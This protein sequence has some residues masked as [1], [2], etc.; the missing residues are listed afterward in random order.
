MTKKLTDWKRSV[1]I[2]W[3]RLTKLEQ[4]ADFEMKQTL[5]DAQAFLVRLHNSRERFSASNTLSLVREFYDDACIQFEKRQKKTIQDSENFSIL[6]QMSQAEKTRLL[7]DVNR[8]LENER[9]AFYE[10]YTFNL[11][12]FDLMPD[13]NAQATAPARDITEVMA[14]LDKLYLIYPVD[15]IKIINTLRTGIDAEAN[16]YLTGNDAYDIVTNGTFFHWSKVGT[17]VFG[18]LILPEIVIATNNSKV[19]RR[20]GLAILQSGLIAIKLANSN[21]EARIRQ[22]FSEPAKPERLPIPE[23][24]EADPVAEYIGGGALLIQN[25][26][27]TSGSDLFKIQKFDNLDIDSTDGFDAKQMYSTQRV[28]FGIHNERPFLIIPWNKAN[29]QGRNS[30]EIQND[31]AETGFSDVIQFDGGGEFY[32]NS[33][34][35]IITKGKNSP[36][37]FAVKIIKFKQE[38]E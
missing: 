27:P 38:N 7:E 29:K 1:R 22:Y 21:K 15:R 4:N 5:I 3:K 16:R 12:L 6:H 36:T 10:Q 2:A 26:Q 20:G 35:L 14:A 13:K 25:G 30:R 9:K 17:S 19:E 24:F 32:M 37:G 8:T 31:L 11:K 23:L 18:T 28:V 34:D 33:K